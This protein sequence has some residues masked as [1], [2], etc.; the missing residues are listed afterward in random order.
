M[1]GFSLNDF[2]LILMEFE[3]KVKCEWIIRG[4]IIIIITI[5]I[6]VIRSEFTNLDFGLVVIN[7]FDYLSVNF[8]FITNQSRFQFL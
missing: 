7:W 3:V 5:I 6:V 2:I 8:N 4:F 1:D